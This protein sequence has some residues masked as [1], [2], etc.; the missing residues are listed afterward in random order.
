MSKQE[1]VDRKLSYTTKEAVEAT[2]IYRQLLYLYRNEGLLNPIKI[3]RQF[4]WV[5]KD[6]EHFLNWAS[7][8]KLTNHETIAIAKKKKP[9]M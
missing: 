1:L 7:G 3:G 9:F 4:I 5:K 6:L 2:G 8:L